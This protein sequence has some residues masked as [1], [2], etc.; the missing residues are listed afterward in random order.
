MTI[1]SLGQL[2]TAMR[3]HPP[4]IE[5]LM[6]IPTLLPLLHKFV[7][8]LFLRTSGGDYHIQVL[9]GSQEDISTIMQTIG[10]W[11]KSMSQGMWLTDLQLAEESTCIRWLLFS[12]GDYDCEALTQEIWNFMGVQVAVRFCTL[13][14]RKKVDKSKKPILKCCHHC[15]L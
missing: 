1:L 5:N 2:Q 9:M 15:L 6:D 12:A 14:D 4:L 7:H 11:L 8:K 10:W 13:D 3:I